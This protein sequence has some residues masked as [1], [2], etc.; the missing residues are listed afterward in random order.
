VNEYLA[1]PGATGLWAAGDC[2]AVPDPKTGKPYPPTAQHAS[3]EGVAAAKNIERAILGRP[4]EP[5]RYTT[6][7]LLASIGHR[8]GVAMVCGIKFSGLACVVVLEDA[9]PLKASWA[10]Q[11]ASGSGDLDNKHLLR[12]R[13]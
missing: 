10:S 12:Q 11:K 6:L 3:R 1:I 2:A 7:G 9:L 13:D 8:T 4:L 5:F